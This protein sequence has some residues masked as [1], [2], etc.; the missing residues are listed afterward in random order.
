MLEYEPLMKE[1]IKKVVRKFY[2]P[3]HVVITDIILQKIMLYDTEICERMKMLLKEFNKLVIKLKEDKIIK[4]EN[5]FENQDEN[6]QILRTVYY[7]NYAEVRDVI[8]YK[9]F[10]MTKNI[11]SNIKMANM[12]GYI[13]SDCGKEYS[14]LDAQSLMEN[15][16]FKCEEC[17]GELI[18]NKKSNSSDCAIHTN[19]ISELDDIIKLLKAT[20]N[21]SI[22]SMDYF[23]ILEMKK[24]KEEAPVVEKQKKIE[25]APVINVEET[26]NTVGYVNVQEEASAQNVEIKEVVF[27]NGVEKLFS[28]ITEEDKEMMNEEEYEKYFEVYEKYNE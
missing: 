11:E 5:K 2:E 15:Y 20:D 7:I 18:E 1:L 14:S 8:K 26:E 3:H 22:P 13:C 27:V 6:R 17:K 28:E 10:K 4:Y 12:E 21:F 23:Q 24:E 16:V 19:L 9:I 25:A